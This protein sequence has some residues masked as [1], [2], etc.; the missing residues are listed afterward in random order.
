[1]EDDGLLE[2]MKFDSDLDGFYSGSGSTVNLQPKPR[3][4]GNTFEEEAKG[5]SGSLPSAEGGGVASTATVG[6]AAAAAAA[7]ATAT[8]SALMG[9]KF[10]MAQGIVGEAVG[11]AVEN[12]ASAAVPASLQPVKAKAGAFLSKAQPWRDFLW[13]LS[14]P[15]ANEGCTRVTAN[16]YNFQ[17]NYAI[18]FVVNLVLAIIFQPSALICI[19]MTVVVW[20][21]F[22]KKNDDPSWTPAIGGV[23]LG[24][25]QRVLL[26]AATTLIILLIIAGSTIFNSAL[27]YMFV[28]FVHGIIHDPSKLTLPGPGGGPVPL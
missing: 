20:I 7:T 8:A 13:P 12:I 15:S 19:A 25:I 16:V 18:L 21:F 14:I 6:A 2:D 17:T 1:M 3:T 28:A 27:M 26:L 23:Q 5:E 4:I 9:G 24:P 10:S 11:N 22:L